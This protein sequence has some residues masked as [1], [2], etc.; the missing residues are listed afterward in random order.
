[1][2][3]PPAALV[4]TPSLVVR[5]MTIGTQNLVH[6]IARAPNASR[7]LSERQRRV[8]GVQ[9]PD[10]AIACL[11]RCREQSACCLPGPL[12]LATAST[13]S[14]VFDRGVAALADDEDLE[15]VV[16]GSGLQVRASISSVAQLGDELERLAP[17]RVVAGLGRMLGEQS[18]GLV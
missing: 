15:R 14:G 2:A 8:L 17:R 4:I 13:A 12:D 3:G 6:R 11:A 18:H 5:L 9:P 10:L 7:D 16:H 1:M